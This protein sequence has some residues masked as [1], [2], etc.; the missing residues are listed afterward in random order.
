MFDS[1]RNHRRWL[2]LF[3]LLLV[4]PSFVF[5]GVQGY[6]RFMEGDRAVAHVGGQPITPQEFEAAQRQQLDRIREQL[7]PNFDP[8]MFDTPQARARILDQLIAQKAVAVETAKSHVLVSPARVIEL[9]QSVPA[10]QQDGKFNYERYKTLLAAQGQSEQSFE[11]RVTADL[12]QQSLVRAVADTS[13]VPKAVTDNVQRLIEEEREIR[14]LRFRPED[15]ASQVKIGDTAITDFYNNNKAQFETPES[16]KAEYVVLTLDAVASQVTVTE[17]ELRKAYDENKARYGREEQRRASHI[18]ITAGDNGSAKDKDGA[19]KLAEEVL[20]KVKANPGDFAKLA[21][22]YSKDP[23]SAANGGDL[24]LFGRNM[25]VKPFEDAAFGMK[26]GDISNVVESDF[27][28][29]II[30][31]TKI[32]PAQTKPFE[33]VRGE[34]EADYKRQQATKKFAEAAE[35]F[36]NTVYEQADSLKPVA[37]KLKLPIQVAENVTRQGV[38]PAPGK[39]NV[40]TPRVIEALFA[41]E[42]IKNGRNTE[43][44]ETAPNTLVAARVAQYRPATQL[45]IEV[46]RDQIKSRLERTE[47]AK[48]AKEAGTKKLA[49]LSAAPSDAGFSKPRTVSRSKPEG[50]A[51]AALKAVMRAPTAKLP[52]FVGAELDGD[53]YGVFQV[54]S[55][56]M[57][58]QAETARKEQLTRSIQQTLGT[59]DN[60]AYVAALKTKYK[61]EVVQSNLKSDA[62][63]PAFDGKDSK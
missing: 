42:A 11:A 16:L 53:A 6:N 28:F 44:I 34:I 33:E 10:F 56:K 25:M 50:M 61:A 63:T 22:Q 8:K 39:P 35:T 30:R 9:I 45:P 24:G 43:D 20:A 60:D 12:V 48:L 49:E 47:A 46:V 31:L 55:V 59:G 14:E 62:A 38:P 54:L 7:G 26:E 15:F 23:G 4:F 41:P 37:E 58:A 1:I 5:F 17:D 18:L 36:K 52:A 57:P 32:E 51:E 21:K 19:R 40:F 2:M 13:F 3:L 27:G 29:H